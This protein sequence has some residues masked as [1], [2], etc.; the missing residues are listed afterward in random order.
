MLYAII[1]LLRY[2][3]CLKGR[4]YMDKKIQIG[5]NIQKLRERDNISQLQLAEKLGV[6][7][8]TV[9]Q[10]E[11]GVIIPDTESLVK[12]SKLF[13]V[14]TD[15]LLMEKSQESTKE[16]KGKGKEDFSFDDYP[17]KSGVGHAMK[18]FPFPVLAV[19]A[20]LILGFGYGL[21]NPGWLV[22]LTVPIYYSIV[23]AIR[24]K[25]DAL[26][27]L[28][29]I[30]LAIIYFILGFLYGV[31]HPLWIIFITIP[32]YYWLIDLIRKK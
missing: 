28:Y 13:G 7:L 26:R 4:E 6:E 2:K 20:Y 16:Q 10:W 25:K 14:S 31:W 9:S 5:K 22:F 8:L 32:L 29:P 23:D 21:W 17:K 12:L 24:G 18:S 19:I 3:C 11:N 27:S 30:F 1:F 15:Y